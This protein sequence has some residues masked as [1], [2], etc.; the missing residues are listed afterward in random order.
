MSQETV[1]AFWNRLQSDVSMQDRLQAEVNPGDGWPGVVRF[2]STNGFEFTEEDYGAAVD[3]LPQ[4]PWEASSEKELT[5]EQLEQVA[6]GLSFSRSLFG[7]RGVLEY[8]SPVR[9]FLRPW[10]GGTP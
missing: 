2:A 8:R 1:K 5:E 10:A 9:R 7:T 4:Q 3:E 6:G